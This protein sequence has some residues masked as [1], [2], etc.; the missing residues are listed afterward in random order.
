MYVW[1]CEYCTIFEHPYVLGAFLIWYLVND[2]IHQNLK[3]TLAWLS[4]NSIAYDVLSN[5]SSNDN[6]MD[7]V[8]TSK[9]LN[10]CPFT[11]GPSYD[12]DNIIDG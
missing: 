8:W 12:N 10:I 11:L 6:T 3:P 5:W 9:Y 2:Q 1:D 4:E 7:Q